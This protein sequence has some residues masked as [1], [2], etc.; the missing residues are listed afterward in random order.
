MTV[1]TSTTGSIAV[2]ITADSLS[3]AKTI[4]VKEDIYKGAT[5]LGS[6]YRNI[7]FTS[8]YVTPIPSITFQGVA[9]TYTTQQ[10]PTAVSSTTNN[11]TLTFTNSTAAAAYG[12]WDNSVMTLT[13][14]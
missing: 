8:A 13:L 12:E 9:T 7:T 2:S 6:T 14:T 11:T 3:A 4:V 10:P 1:T 5:L